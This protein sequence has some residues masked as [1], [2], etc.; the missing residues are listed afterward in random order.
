MQVERFTVISSDCHAGLPPERYRAYLDP[1][2]REAFDQ[3]LPIQKHMTDKAEQVFLL[4]DINEQWRAGVEAQLAGAWD[5]TRRTEVLDA[6]GVAGEIVFP[7]GV[8]EQNAP[9]FGAGLALP[10]KNIVPDL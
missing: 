4:K 1:Q 5:H 10:T 3:V 7:D 9:P 2:Y 8:T 6:D